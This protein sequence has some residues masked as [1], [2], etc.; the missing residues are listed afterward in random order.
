MDA[1]K[2]YGPHKT[3]FNGFI[4]WSR[5][6]V[7]DHIFADLSGE[8]PKPEPITIAAPH[9]RRTGLRRTGVHHA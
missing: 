7:F 4:R 2:G 5:M 1:P 6:G 8:G 9:S 3:L